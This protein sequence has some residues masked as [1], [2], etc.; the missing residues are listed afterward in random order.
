MLPHADFSDLSGPF[1]ASVKLVSERL[2]YSLRSHKGEPKLLRRFTQ[3]EITDCIAREG[4]DTDCLNVVTGANSKPI[5]ALLCDYLNRRADD[6]EACAEPS[7]MDREEA[8]SHFENIRAELQPR[9]YLPENLQRGKK[10]HYNYLTCIVNMLTESALGGVHLDD[11]PHGLAVVT[12]DG[13]P[14]RTFSR[15]MDGAY[16]ARINTP[17]GVGNQGVLWN[18]YLWQSSSR[19]CIRNDARRL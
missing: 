4:L 5:G 10:R 7:L 12:R 6:L 17:C 11:N 15:R 1:W 3:S 18:N 14:L 19:R 2:G 16:P 9:C 8:Q 13:V